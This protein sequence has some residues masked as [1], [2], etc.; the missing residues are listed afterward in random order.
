VSGKRVMQR[1]HCFLVT[2][3]SP[4]T[5]R[6]CSTPVRNKT[7]I[8]WLQIMTGKSAIFDK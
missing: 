7:S 3:F 6:N 2:Q 1:T 4:P 5:G 8:V